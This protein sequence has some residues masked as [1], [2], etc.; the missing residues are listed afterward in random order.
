MTWTFK[1]GAPIYQ[2][3]VQ[4]MKIRIANGTYPPGSKIPAV[5]DLAVEAGVNPN[6][7]QRALAELE[8]EN[9][10]KSERTSGRFVTQDE[11]E[12]RIL[13]EA[14]GHDFIREMFANMTQLGMTPEEVVQA[15]TKWYHTSD[16]AE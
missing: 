9:L 6:T 4:T 8:R 3:I 13:R 2:Q 14:L 1:E 5:R 11:N 10:V 16:P 7:M 15:V 12:L